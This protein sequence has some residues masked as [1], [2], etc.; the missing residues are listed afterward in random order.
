MSVAPLRTFVVE[1]DYGIASLCGVTVTMLEGYELIGLS[2]DS[3]SALE[4]IS[5]EQPDIV[6]LEVS[7][8]DGSGMQLL[9]HMDR[10]NLSCDVVLVLNG[11]IW[12]YMMKGLQLDIFG[13]L[14][15]PFDTRRLQDTLQS[16]RQYRMRRD[17]LSVLKTRL[18]ENKL[19]SSS[20]SNTTM[21][22]KEMEPAILG[23]IQEILGGD[24]AML[25]SRQIA[26]QTGI[27]LTTVR[28]YLKYMVRKGTVK[29]CVS[30]GTTGIPLRSFQTVA[31]P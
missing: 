9:H 26:E 30:F 14:M 2:D 18:P 16:Y 1:D 21:F 3:A 8:P 7:Q 4:R 13:Y 29:E 5:A 6:L 15:K 12:N 20:I 31:E 27:S 23:R 11:P 28:S 10:M 24:Q 17:S 22:K 19:Q 25:T